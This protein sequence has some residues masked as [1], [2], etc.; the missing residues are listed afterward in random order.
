MTG[1]SMQIEVIISDNTVIPRITHLYSTQASE[2][3]FKC[4]SMSNGRIVIDDSYFSDA[5]QKIDITGLD[6]SLQDVKFI[7]TIITDVI[8]SFDVA[9]TNNKYCSLRKPDH[10]AEYTLNE[11]DELSMSYYPFDELTLDDRVYM[12]LF[13]AVKMV[14]RLYPKIKTGELIEIPYDNYSLVSSLKLLN[15]LQPDP[16]HGYNGL[17]AYYGSRVSPD[18][19]EYYRE[20]GLWIET[21]DLLESLIHKLSF[22]QSDETKHEEY[23]LLLR[24]TSM[25]LD[26]ELQD[27]HQYIN[28]KIQ[29]YTPKYTSLEGYKQLIKELTSQVEIIHPRK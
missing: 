28:P 12:M 24:K 19:E 8:E 7:D 3:I 2:F 6:L 27:L 22:M 23:Q 15:E 11:L 29:L 14:A 21:F 1:T 20:N 9:Y 5:K 18:Y 26:Y 25:L 4:N 17:I 13:N 10:I 16:L